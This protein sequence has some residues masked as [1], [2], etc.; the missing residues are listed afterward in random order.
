MKEGIKRRRMGKE[1][2][3]EGDEATANNNEEKMTKVEIGEIRTRA[4]IERPKRKE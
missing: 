2:E 1:R 4:K 3:K